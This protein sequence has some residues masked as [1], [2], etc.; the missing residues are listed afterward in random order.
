MMKRVIALLLCLMLTLGTLAGCVSVPQ[1]GGDETHTHTYETTL[2]YDANDHW[3][4]PTCDCEDAPI[5]KVKHADENNDGKCDI[6]QYASCEH[7]YSEEWTADCTNH[8]HAADCGHIVA[9]SEAAAH[10]D[11]NADGK[12]DVCNYIIEDIH[13]HIYATEWTTDAQYH[14]YAPICEHADAEVTKE[15]HEIDAAGYCT[16]CDMKVNEID[17][18]D[19][20]AVLAAAIA[21][22]DKVTGGRVFEDQIIRDT[23]T[24]YTTSKEIQ[25]AL[26]NGYSYINNIYLGDEKFSDQTWY[27]LMELGE[28]DDTT[29]VFGVN[30][31]DGGAT[32]QTVTGSVENLNG[33]TYNPSTLLAQQNS[34]TLADT[35]SAMYTLSLEETAE[36]V[37]TAYDPETGVYSFSYDYT[38][39]NIVS[40]YGVK[41]VE[42]NI[43]SVAA[44]FTVNELGVI[45]SATFVVD[46]YLQWDDDFTVEYDTNDDGDPINIVCTLNDNAL[47]DS[48]VYNVAQTSGERTYTTAYPKEALTPLSFNFYDANGELVGNT[49]EY[50]AGDYVEWTLDDF[51]P[52]VYGGTFITMEDIEITL[53]NKDDP[54]AETPDFNFYYYCR[55]WDGS[56]ACVLSF[57]PV[58]GN[59]T[60]TINYH[61]MEKVIDL[62]VDPLPAE[63]VSVFEFGY[64][65]NWV[66][67]QEEYLANTSASSTYQ[68]AKGE[69]VDFAALILPEEALQG[70]TYS[71]TKDGEAVE[72]S[73]V[74][75]EE[76]VDTQIYWTDYTDVAKLTF[77]ANEDAVY[78]ITFA[79]NTNPEITTSITLYVGDVEIPAPP[80]TP[81]A[82]SITLTTT[83]TYSWIDEYTYVA[84]AA[85]DYTFHLP[86]GVGLYSFA[87]YDNWG[88]AE[89]PHGMDATNYTVTLEE[90]EEYSFYFGSDTITT[91]YVTVSTPES[92]WLGG[93][94]IGGGDVQ[95]AGDIT[96][97]TTLTDNYQYHASLMAPVG[98]TETWGYSI[99]FATPNLLSFT[100]N[101]AGV[102]AV[103]LPA[104]FGVWSQNA[105]EANG[106]AEVNIIN[107]EAIYLLV[108]LEAGET[109]GFYYGAA[110]A[111]TYFLDVLYLP[112][113]NVS[114][115]GSGSDSGDSMLDGSE[116]Y[117]E[118]LV[119]EALDTYFWS[120]LEEILY[121]FTAD[122]A[123]MYVVVIPENCG[124]WLEETYAD[125]DAMA[126]VD[127]NEN[128]TGTEFILVL[129]AGESISFYLGALE[130]GEHEF[131]IFYLPEEGDGAEGEYVDTV[132]LTPAAAGTWSTETFTPGITVAGTYSLVL[133]AGTAL[134]SS[135]YAF[136]LGFHD[137][138]PAENT[139][140]FELVWY[141]DPAA[142]TS[143]HYYS[144]SGE[145]IEIDIFYLG[146]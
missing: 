58:I 24:S 49:L 118:T 69:A 41:E 126:D 66:T 21:R 87:A 62:T 119:L 86:A 96:T 104:E 39:I 45:N 37:L 19:I 92:G 98:D 110:T 123:G 11:T 35:L 80:V 105:Y 78:V 47:A 111:N 60:M 43:Y 54:T 71:V 64:E 116:V 46:S 44:E 75:T 2:S 9:G 77:I 7:T 109:F 73:S 40:F 102:Y 120:D 4:K 17:K 20:A 31:P 27:Q 144:T 100:A 6:C 36:N 130:A 99:Y 85:G 5:V 145:E 115:S 117:M 83:D 29:W 103:C 137:M 107:S 70:Y 55:S 50:N 13:V 79:C 51:M 127:F 95:P 53:V 113:G 12:C 76:L 84:S 23:A 91:Y 146:E 136:E 16:V 68:I 26:G 3:Y 38:E 93:G 25:F 143:F 57:M 134:T 52:S 42:A 1:D 67:S 101:A 32:L 128:A 28:T 14:W 94:D 125:F 122:E 138:V 10:T 74:I 22:N 90:G 15:A 89:V 30:S 133:P 88:D 108:T 112:E 129:E 48:Y 59:Y 121:T 72:N 140:G 97:S 82:V 81:G 114:G 132:T 139:D 18:T 65:Y 135:G 106:F 142:P 141:L 33:F 34:S 131:D 63:A 124:I 8:W 61:G 56:N